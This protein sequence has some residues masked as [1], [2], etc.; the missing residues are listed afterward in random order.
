MKKIKSNNPIII[1][2]LAIIMIVIFNIFSWINKDGYT[3]NLNYN[4]MTDSTHTYKLYNSWTNA[5][6]NINPIDSIKLEIDP[7]TKD[8]KYTPTNHNKSKIKFTQWMA[9]CNYNK[10]YFDI[11]HFKLV[12]FDGR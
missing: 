7:N 6:F 3:I 10:E 4:D 11:N 2:I 1:I 9:I 12:M 8:Y 5:I